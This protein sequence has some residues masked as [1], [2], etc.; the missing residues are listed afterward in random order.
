MDTASS[1][2]ELRRAVCEGL[3]EDS[4]EFARK[5][6]REGTPPLVVLN[7]GVIAG[8]EEAGRLWREGEYFIP[9]VILSAEAFRA[10]VEFLKP[11]LATDD[12]GQAGR[13]MIGTVAGD[14]HDLGKN[15]VVAMLNGSGFEVLDLGVNV[16]THTFVEKVAEMKPDILGIGAYM[17]TTMLVI[18]D[19]ISA[20]DKAGLRRSVAIMIGG[21][22]ITDHFADQVG[23]NGYA[24]DAVAAVEVAKR[25]MEAR[26]G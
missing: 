2:Q 16:P 11:N 12:M 24:R 21:V 6:I 5:A 7:E 20:L 9:E 19:V 26:H 4:L 1:I 8:L 17:S 10:C 15:I 3:V 13:F 14:M 25:L 18:R 22:P 23:A